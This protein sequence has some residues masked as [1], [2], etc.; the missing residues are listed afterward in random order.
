MRAVLRSA[1]GRAKNATNV[2]LPNDSSLDDRG[3][4]ARATLVVPVENLH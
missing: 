2:S 1:C 3:I 4:D